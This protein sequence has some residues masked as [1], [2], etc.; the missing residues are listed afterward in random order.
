MKYSCFCENRLLFMEDRCCNSFEDYDSTPTPTGDNA[1]QKIVQDHSDYCEHIDPNIVKKIESYF[2]KK[3]KNKAFSDIVRQDMVDEHAKK[4]YSIALDSKEKN[5]RE[6][7]EMSDNLNAIKTFADTYY[8]NIVKKYPFA[9]TEKLPT[10]PDDLFITKTSICSSIGGVIREYLKR[11]NID[12]LLAVKKNSIHHVV[13]ALIGKSNK[14]YG[15]VLI[16]TNTGGESPYIKDGVEMWNWR[17]RPDISEPFFLNNLRNLQDV[18]IVSSADHDEAIHGI[19]SFYPITDEDSQLFFK[20]LS[21]YNM[22]KNV[23]QTQEKKSILSQSIK[24]LVAVMNKLSPDHPLRLDA[25]GRIKKI[26]NYLKQ[27]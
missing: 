19:E 20:A 11:M 14:K 1:L 15:A 7:K 26:I 25:E 17:D 13:I 27:D 18:P 2:A 5:I 6:I 23:H 24:D 10:N 12:S 16:D 3:E 4:G 9:W 8:P 22:A 21:E